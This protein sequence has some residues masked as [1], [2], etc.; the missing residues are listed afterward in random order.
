MTPQPSSRHAACSGPAGARTARQTPGAPIHR[1]PTPT[2]EEDRNGHRE[3]ERRLETR[4]TARA[5]LRG[6]LERLDQ[7]ELDQHPLREHEPLEEQAG[8]AVVRIE[9]GRADE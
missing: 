6:A 1:T 2:S 9:R 3:E 7:I 4:A 5:T 8:A